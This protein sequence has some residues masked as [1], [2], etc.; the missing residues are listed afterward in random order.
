MNNFFKTI[1]CFTMAILVVS[2]SKD[3]DNTEPLRDYAVQYATDIAK[4]EE[5]L[6]T[7]YITVV[8]H[9]GFADDQSVT[10]TKIPTGG[11]QTSI[12]NSPDLVTNFTVDAND[13]TYKLY[14]LKLR[15]HIDRN[16]PTPPTAAELA[17]T[18][19]NVDRVLTSYVGQY[20]YT[21]QESNVDVLKLKQFEENANPQ[22]FF[23]L[24]STIRGW[25][26]VF[27]RFRAGT[28]VGNPDGTLSYSDFGAGIIFIPSGL[29][30]FGN[31]TSAIPAYSP[32]IFTFKLY[33]IQRV[34]ND[35]DGIYSF[36]EDL[37][38]DGYVRVLEEGIVNPDDTDGDETP[39]FL[40][41]DDDGDLV[42]TKTEIKNPLTGA[43]YPFDQ[44]PTCAANGN[45]KVHVSAACH[46]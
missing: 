8:D 21:T 37:N 16:A 12:W 5:F 14:Y 31:G 3:D 45:K 11:T 27:P 26:E 32:L 35:G 4:I 24:S 44:I 41:V 40:D 9:A 15:G 20:L 22:A 18:P 39:D 25:S 1:V 30:Y 13:V 10:F 6:Q 36:Q 43:A 23:A 2:C 38:N 28:Y 34:D 33:E 19:C 29:G 7:H 42:M 46:P 17:K